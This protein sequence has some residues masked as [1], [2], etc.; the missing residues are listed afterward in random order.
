MALATP[1]FAMTSPSAT[2]RI[3]Q[4]GQATPPPQMSIGRLQTSLRSKF[5]IGWLPKGVR[6]S[7]VEGMRAGWHFRDVSWRMALFWKY[8]RTRAEDVCRLAQTARLRTRAL[9]SLIS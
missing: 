8:A 3:Q 2:F 9:T 7:H 4:T 6:G 1:M 5:M